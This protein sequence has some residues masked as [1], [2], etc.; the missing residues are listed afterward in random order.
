MKK[1]LCIFLA[2]ILV[3]GLFGCGTTA[4]A[5]ET[6]APEPTAAAEEPASAGPAPEEPAESPAVEKNG[7]I[8]ILYTADVHCGVDKGFG[9]AGLQQVRDAL[10]ARG[11]EVILADGGDSVQ[12]EPI[13][14]MTRGEAILDLMNE[15]GYDVA[16]PG[17]HEFDYGMEQFFLLKEKADYPYISC[18]FNRQGELMLE[19]FVIR[20]LAGRKI[21]FV[22]VTTPETL[23]SSTPRYFQNESG[24]YVYGFFQDESGDGLYTAVQTAVD[25]ARAEGAEFVI[26]LAHLGNQA[27]CSPWTYAD[28]IS[29]TNGIDVLFDGHSHDT[30]QVV[31]KNKDGQE[32]IRCATGTK[33]VNIGW[34]RI[35]AQGEITS[36]LYTWSNTE[37]APVL[38][39]IDNEMSRAVAAKMDSLNDVLREVVAATAVELTI[40]DPEAVDSNGN[41]IRMIRRAETNLGDLCADAYRDQS[42]ADIAF[43][44]GGGIRVSLPAGDITFSDILRVHPYGNYL[45]VA[46][47]TGQQILDAL[48]WGARAVPGEVG[49]F[50]QT[51]GLTYEIHTYI[52]HS[53]LSDEMSMFKG[54]A[55]ERRVKNVMVGD[56]PLDPERVYTLAATDYILIDRGDGYSMFA[57]SPLLQ[58]S[59]KLDNQVLIDY[60]VGT[61]GGVVGEEYS[62]LY[63][64]GRIVIV[65]EK[66]AEG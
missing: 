25:N 65:E 51:S 63:G 3:L 9:Y 59:V 57:G 55:G 46:E 39:G 5:A 1:T 42:G 48:E 2:L 60:I 20:E 12:G 7:E 8:V 52:E 47:V 10:L 16:I 11:Y 30:D 13:G 36:G 35:D 33:L 34:C 31:M 61:L 54:V 40:F 66:P 21:A 49:G 37:S 15:I 14:T 17:N 24:E 53:C 6:A 29:H 26:A 27:E 43:V 64:Q 38:L 56:E 32:V 19:P 4:R 58:N 44:N 28:V 18:N 22:G 23:T 50:L 45:C 41:P 62:D